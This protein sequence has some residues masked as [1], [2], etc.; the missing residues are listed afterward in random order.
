V[1]HL[2]GWPAQTYNFWLENIRDW[3]IS[4]QLWWGHRIPVYY[5]RGADEGEFVVARSEAAAYEKAREKYGADVQLEQDPDVLDTWF[6][7]S[8]RADGT[9]RIRWIAMCIDFLTSPVVF[10]FVKLFHI[11][12]SFLSFMNVVAACL[13]VH[14]HQAT[15]RK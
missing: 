15:G 12:F 6:S 10:S 9:A 4:R 7:R 14:R 8:E 11:L 2:H 3:C 13:V 1:L 5:V